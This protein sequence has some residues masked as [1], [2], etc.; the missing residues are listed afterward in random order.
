MNIAIVNSPIPGVAILH[1]IKQQTNN[2]LG[3]VSAST[4]TRQYTISYSV[5]FELSIFKHQA[6]IAPSTISTYKSLII[7]SN[8]ILGSSSEEQTILQEMRQTLAQMIIAKL[9]S[10]NTLQQLQQT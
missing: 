1:I 8:Q 10:G 6:I 3:S 9:A 2:S 5:V 4:N 7:N